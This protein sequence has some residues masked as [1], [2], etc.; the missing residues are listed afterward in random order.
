[1]RM[2]TTTLAPVRG[3][4]RILRD[5]STDE[6]GH[7][8]DTVNASATLAFLVGIGLAI[9]GFVT[10]RA[11]NLSEY[12]LGVGGLLAATTGAQRFKPP[13]RPPAG[14]PRGEGEGD[15]PDRS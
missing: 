7:S 4:G 9:A 12:A 10:G 2:L 3:L 14:R 15:D 13:A 5:C 11:F 1:M 8:Y 6:Y